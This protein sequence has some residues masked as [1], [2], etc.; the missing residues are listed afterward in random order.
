[1]KS[2]KAK[3]RISSRPAAESGR[4][5]IKYINKRMEEKDSLLR[6]LQKQKHELDMSIEKA[7]K[8]AK[9]DNKAMQ[10]I[11]LSK[12]KPAQSQTQY[13]NKFYKSVQKDS[14]VSPPN[15]AKFVMNS[16]NS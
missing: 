9:I 10:Q 6:Q 14:G 7:E 4:A 1:M 12:S 3:F 2:P 5:I 15:K 11:L 13:F 8:K 16:L